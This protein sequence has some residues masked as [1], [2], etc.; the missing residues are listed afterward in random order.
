MF[1]LINDSCLILHCD[2]FTHNRL[3]LPVKKCDGKRTLLAIWSL[4]NNN[5]IANE[6]IEDDDDALMPLKILEWPFRSNTKKTTFACGA[7]DETNR[8]VAICDSEK[9]LCIFDSTKNFIQVKHIRLRRNAIKIQ[10]LC[11]QNKN[12]VLVADKSGNIYQFDGRPDESAIF[13][14][15]GLGDNFTSGELLLGHCSML[16][17]FIVTE[18]KDYII[19]ADRDEKIRISHYP[20]T[21]NIL[22][23]CLGHRDFV[24]TIGLIDKQTLISGSGDGSLLCW[25]YLHGKTLHQYQY[26]DDSGVGE[27]KERTKIK[28]LIVEKKWRQFFCV[29]FHKQSHI[30]IFK[31]IYDH[32]NCFEA[33]EKCHRISVDGFP[34]SIHLDSIEENIFVIQVLL[35][36]SSTKKSIQC[37]QVVSD[38]RGPIRIAEIITKISKKFN[39]DVKFFE[40]IEK[41]YEDEVIAFRNLSKQAHP[42]AF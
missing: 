2:N 33:I 12:F 28:C 38:G 3:K 7:F 9:N 6:N 26:T 16:L 19:S 31:I 29:I 42:N 27:D 21:Y 35:A 13:E 32:Q 40:S 1:L 8:L 14:D 37:F 10:F 18:N 15:N 34:L 36:K 11:F 39:D 4:E 22:S 24:G 5:R 41:S 20:N 23:Y 30:D 17:D 25:N